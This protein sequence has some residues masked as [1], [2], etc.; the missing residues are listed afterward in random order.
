MLPGLNERPLLSN[1]LDAGTQWTPQSLATDTTSW[2]ATLEALRYTLAYAGLPPSHI[3][4]VILFVRGKIMNTIK[5][6][7]QSEMASEGGADLIDADKKHILNTCKEMARY[8]TEAQNESDASLLEAGIPSIARCLADIQGLLAGLEKPSIPPALRLPVAGDP[9]TACGKLSNFGRFRSD[10]SLEGFVGTA[11]TPPIAI[12]G[13]CVR[14]P[15]AL[16]RPPS[17]FLLRLFG[18]TF[19]ECWLVELTKMGDN[20]VTHQ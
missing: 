11:P 18:L 16:L 13:A 8:C 12:P 19:D 1:S 2:N 4:P 10:L 20:V 5:A 3:A 6:S 9:N 7:L 17:S 14:V 15:S